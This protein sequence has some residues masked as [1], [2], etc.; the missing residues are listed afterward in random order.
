MS[1]LTETPWAGRQW[2]DFRNLGTS[3]DIVEFGVLG[4]RTLYPCL[5]ETNIYIVGDAPKPVTE[6]QAY[7]PSPPLIS[8]LG[9]HPRSSQH[10]NKA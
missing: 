2:L 1:D 3:L 9:S 6:P 8:H 4:S 7:M 10:A 5:G